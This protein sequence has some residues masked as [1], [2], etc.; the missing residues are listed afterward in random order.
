MKQILS[1]LLV[2][3]ALLLAGCYSEQDIRDAR[4]EGYDEG[5]EEGYRSGYRDGEEDFYWYGYDEGCYDGSRG[6]CY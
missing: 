3:S 1:F 2:T 6:N 5:Y 4:N